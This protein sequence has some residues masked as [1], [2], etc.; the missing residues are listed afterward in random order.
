MRFYRVAD[1]LGAAEELGSGCRE[2]NNWDAALA[3]M[4]DDEGQGFADGVAREL[5]DALPPIKGK[6]KVKGEA[7]EIETPIELK[8]RKRFS[9]LR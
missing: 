5:S 6:A 2:G 1:I 7:P 4:I 9:L 3:P 8:P